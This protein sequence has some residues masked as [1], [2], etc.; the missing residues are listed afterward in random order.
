MRYQSDP[1]KAEELSRQAEEVVLQLPLVA[2]IGIKDH[3]EFARV[4]K[5]V[6]NSMDVFLGPNKREVL[7]PAY[8]D[9]DITRVEFGPDSKLVREFLRRE[10]VLGNLFSPRLY[11]ATIE[12]GWYFGLSPEPLRD[13]I[14]R[15]EA[16]RL[17]KDKEQGEEVAINSSFYVSPDAAVKAGAF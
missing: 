11:Y 10:S 2:G 9:V 1:A 17:G 8:K 6:Q 5:D 4:F 7:K 12:D 16:R 3:K 15:A 13:L 14:D